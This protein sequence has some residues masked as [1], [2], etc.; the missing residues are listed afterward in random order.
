MIDKNTIQQV[1]G[2]LMLHPQYLSHVDK[3][4]L[5]IKDFSSKFEQYIFLAINNIYREAGATSIN[6]IDIENYLDSDATA[7]KIFEQNNGIEYLNDIVELSNSETF[8]YYYTKLKKLNLLRD[9]KRQGIDTKEFYIEDLTD[10]NY[11]KV[12]S[13]FESL[14]TKDIC[15]LVKKKLLQLETKYAVSEEIQTYSL[16][17]GLENI[18]NGIGEIQGIG[19]SVQG[20]IYNQVISGAVPGTLTI[21]SGASGTA[22]T[23]SAVMDAAYL[24]FPYRFNSSRLM[25]ERI[26]SSENILFII[27][28][29]SLEQIQKMIL[30]YL[31]DINES[32]FKYGKFN[33][34]EKILISQAFKIMKEYENNFTIIKMPEPTI[35]GLKTLI[36]ETCLTRKIDIVFFDYIF[37]NP[38]LLREFR[39][40]NLRNDELL[41]MMSTALKDLAVELDVPIF[42]STQVNAA[43]DDNRNIRNEA[44]LAGGRSTI[45]KADNGCII[46][47]PTKEELDALKKTTSMLGIPNIVTDIYKV[48]SGEW[49]QV[50]IWSIVDLGT[51]R[52][53]DLF[54][55]D[56]RLDIIPNFTAIDEYEVNFCE[57]EESVA[58]RIGELN[59]QLSRNN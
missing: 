48:R 59:D 42:T 32:R 39:G 2:S 38:G 49:T 21:R 25:W 58:K 47:R 51:L 3:Y 30:A 27:T 14:S 15:D 10:P 18:I 40:F 44:S 1:L 29:Q 55:T 50:R 36:R 46:A 43:A 22:K 5:S 12:N 54:I 53:K 26:G 20:N 9:L 28:E 7:A 35:D 8:P 16:T 31:T 11:E 41:L 34:F 56:A 4:N 37:I 13:Q 19:P 23:R 6:P 57:D 33:D 45:N 52:R 17:S 24:C